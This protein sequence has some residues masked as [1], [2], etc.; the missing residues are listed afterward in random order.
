MSIVVTR[1]A[2][3]AALD[4]S[5]AS[6]T[7]RAILLFLNQFHTACWLPPH[8]LSFW[9][10]FAHITTVSEINSSSSLLFIA[11]WAYDCCPNTFELRYVAV[12]IP[13]HFVLAT[14]RLDYRISVTAWMGVWNQ[15]T[16][17]RGWLS[18]PG[19]GAVFGLENV[20]TGS[21]SNPA[22]YLL[23]TGVLCEGWSE[24]SVTFTTVLACSGEL[25]TEELYTPPPSCLR[26]MYVTIPIFTVHYLL[27][28]LL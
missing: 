20:Q 16:G 14:L 28:I 26:D 11:L 19:W 2:V 4:C 27:F 15:N 6:V 24:R 13:F 22:P 9:C 7:L 23:V 25:E 3:R 1:L 18:N 17:R 8:P 12:C 10:I 21:G 5:T